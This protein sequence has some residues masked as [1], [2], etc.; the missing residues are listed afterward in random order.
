MK[1]V[2]INQVLN[3]LELACFTPAKFTRLQAL[4][5]DRSH[6]T[7]ACT[8]CNLQVKRSHALTT[9]TDCYQ[10]PLIKTGQACFSIYAMARYGA[11]CHEV[12]PA[13]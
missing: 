13:Q 8:D 10:P 4:N 5:I 11:P 12:R 7:N 3:N 9:S 1:H 2:N 6:G